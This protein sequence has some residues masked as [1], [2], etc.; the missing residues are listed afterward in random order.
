DFT[1][2]VTAVQVLELP[3]PTDEWVSENTGEFETVDEWRAAMTERLSQR[4]LGGVRQQV[5]GKLTGALVE[6]V[7]I[8]APESMVQAEMQQQLQNLFRQLQ[9]QGID[10]QAWFSATGQ[11][12]QQLLEG[13]RPQA[14]QAVKADLALRA[15]AT[16]E[17][18]DATDGDIE[19]E[20]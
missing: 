17:E 3:E 2:T 9:M 5:M 13:T 19:I 12:P 15:I 7:D 11:S 8:D 14:E 6:L 18:L 1:V 10:P 16:A 4:K 20:Y